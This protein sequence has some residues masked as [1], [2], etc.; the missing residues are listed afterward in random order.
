LLS[1]HRKLPIYCK[2]RN[3][4]NLL[5]SCAIEDK[6][7]QHERSRFS[8]NHCRRFFDVLQS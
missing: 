8:L 1:S 5:W 3:D 4:G 7:S 2:E 6:L